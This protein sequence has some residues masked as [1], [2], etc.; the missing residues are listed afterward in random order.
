MIW[1]SW[2]QQRWQ[3]LTLLGLLVV[4]VGTI[5]LLRSNMLD[6]IDSAGLARCVADAEGCDAPG[7]AVKAFRETWSTP[8][9]LAQ[10][11][12]MALPIVIGIFIGAPLFARELEEGTHVLAFTQSV[13]RTRW[14]FSKL[15]VALVPALVVLVA[16]QAAV[17][18]WVSAAGE[19]GPLWNGPFRSTTFAA[20]HVSPVGY[21]LFAFA[22]CTFLGVVT[23]RTLVA[24]TSSFGA[25]LVVRLALSV[26]PERLVP[27]QRLE[28]AADADRLSVRTPIDDGS[29][30]L[31]SGQLDA[32]GRPV[33]HEHY[34]AVNQACKDAAGSSQDA[35]L[36]CLPRSGIAK[37]YWAYIPES[38]AWQVHLADGAIFGVLAALLLAGT[39]WALRR[40][41]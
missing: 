24:M 4:G 5:A 3:L 40:Q 2:R 34:L 36:A 35:F 26:V 9:D 15:V 31:D 33:S 20:G 25:F 19:L 21:A 7:G 22:L 29:V 41:S 32:A 14:M 11:V 38:H 10:G 37:S 18:W 12:I 13:S 1:T 30:V 8:L 39:V 17:S 28:I 27:Q 6:A 16:L 23:R